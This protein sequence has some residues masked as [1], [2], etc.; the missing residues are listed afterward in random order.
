MK[1][2][3]LDPE[4]NPGS[5]AFPEDARYSQHDLRIHGRTALNSILAQ[6]CLEDIESRQVDGRPEVVFFICDT[7]DKG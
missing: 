4:E 6:V 5:L 2:L 3:Y 7:G 1:L